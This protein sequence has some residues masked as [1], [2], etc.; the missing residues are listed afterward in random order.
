MTAMIDP[1]IVL[2]KQDI[3]SVVCFEEL[4]EGWLIATNNF[5]MADRLQKKRIMVV[6]RLL[7]CVATMLLA[8]IVIGAQHCEHESVTGAGAGA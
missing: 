2:F 3:M 7:N 8:T 6:A 1:A 5:V 4:P